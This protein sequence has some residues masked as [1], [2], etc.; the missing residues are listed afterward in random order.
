MDNISL[1]CNRRH[2]H[3]SSHI[4]TILLLYS[5]VLTWHGRIDNPSMHRTIM[6]KLLTGPSSVSSGEVLVRYRQ[7]TSSSLVGALLA[8]KKASYFRQRWRNSPDN[9]AG[10]VRFLISRSLLGPP[11]SLA[12]L[13]EVQYEQTLNSPGRASLNP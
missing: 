6:W 5:T 9:D 4:I 12:P 7:W 11:G 1:E 2:S 8:N 13:Y 10:V 3:S